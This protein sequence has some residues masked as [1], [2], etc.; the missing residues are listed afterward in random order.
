M[1]VPG[2][3]TLPAQQPLGQVLALQVLPPLHRPAL[4]V[5]PLAH[6]PQVSPPA[7]HAEVLV[8]TWQTLPWQHPSGQFSALQVEPPTH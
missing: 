6:T 4:Q 2:W 5:W 8:P 7:P 1:E 3:H